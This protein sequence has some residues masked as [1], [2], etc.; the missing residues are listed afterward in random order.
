M[1]S[2]SSVVSITSCPAR[3][4]TLHLLL[5]SLLNQAF[6]PNKIVLCLD[7]NVEINSLLLKVLKMCS[8]GLLKKH[9]LRYQ[10]L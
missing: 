5:K 1:N 9:L 6:C 10:T 8:Q 2:K 7:K 3:F 4:R